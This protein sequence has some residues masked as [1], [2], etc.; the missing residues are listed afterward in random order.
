MTTDQSTEQALHE[1]FNYPKLTPAEL[2][3][4]HDQGFLLLKSVL[5]PAGLD[6]MVSECMA[7]WEAEKKA[8]D[9]SKSW[10]DNALLLDIHRRSAVVRDYYFRGPLVDIASAIIGPNVKGVASQLTFKMRGNTKAFPWHQDNAYGELAPY[11]SVTCLTALEANDLE[12]GCLWVL[13][14]NNQRGQSS[15]G[16]RSWKKAPA[17]G[18]HGGG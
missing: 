4:Y 7:A 13:P 10:L 16:C 17:R 11:N 15:P 12:T 3:T 2:A 18:C 5:K 8:F 9:P 14:E 1:W 6:R